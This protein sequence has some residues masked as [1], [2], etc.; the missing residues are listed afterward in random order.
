M[1]Q[2]GEK[3]TGSEKNESKSCWPGTY[4]DADGEKDYTQKCWPNG[5]R[6]LV[7]HYYSNGEI[8]GKT[9]Y[10]ESGNKHTETIYFSD[11]SYLVYAYYE[12]GAGTRYS[13]DYD[14]GI[15]TREETYYE[16]WD[17]HNKK[18]YIWYQ[19]KG[20]KHFGYPFCY[21]DDGET[22]E[23]CTL[24]KHGCTSESDTCIQ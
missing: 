24:A 18:T 10:Y 12:S 20:Q 11:K 19:S 17:F 16:S 8:L 14:D 5:N 15:K 3:P 6:K 1:P 9:S 7:T 4:E 21:E 13:I 2:Q 22:R 23:T